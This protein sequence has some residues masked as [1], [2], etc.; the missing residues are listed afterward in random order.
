MVSWVN[1]FITLKA[2][3]LTDLDKWGQELAD[4]IDTHRG[5]NPYPRFFVETYDG[6]TYFY[7]FTTKIAKDCIEAFDKEVKEF[8]EK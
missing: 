4:I 2:D 1:R 5:T 3:N 6:L 7:S 8:I